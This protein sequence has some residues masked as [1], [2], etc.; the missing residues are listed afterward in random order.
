MAVEQVAFDIPE[1]I[2]KKIKSGEFIR[3]GGIVRD[4]AGHIIAHLK[5]IQPERLLKK[6]KIKP[7]LA[8]GNVV[9]KTIKYINN[10]KQDVAKVAII[11]IAIAGV[12]YAIYSNVI[13]KK[14]IYDEIE[15]SNTLN[16]ISMIVNS[17]DTA[18]NKYYEAIQLETTNYETINN[19]R[20]EFE[21]IKNE[22][23]RDNLSYDVSKKNL[24]SLATIIQGYGNELR[25][26][27]GLD[28]CFAINIDEFSQSELIDFIIIK[29]KEQE[30]V[31]Q[32]KVPEKE[33]EPIIV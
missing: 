17:Y 19:L 8:D 31:F 10:N 12:S 30:E 1:E 27:N 23:E 14:K 11:W 33:L 32:L 21:I 4:K 22:I 9:E 20:K 28:N 7:K 15:N 16:E 3:I 6:T 2:S 29:L 13:E 25:K 26:A 5:E 24:K 18:L